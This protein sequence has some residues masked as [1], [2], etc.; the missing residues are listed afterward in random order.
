MAAVNFG[1]S[2]NIQ[3]PQYSGKNNLSKP[4]NQTKVNQYDEY[5][6]NVNMKELNIWEYTIANFSNKSINLGTVSEIR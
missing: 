5:N 2:G 6:H 3:I 4:D 1:E